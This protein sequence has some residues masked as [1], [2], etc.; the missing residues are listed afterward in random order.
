MYRNKRSLF[1]LVPLL[2]ALSA[3]LAVVFTGAHSGA[4]NAQ[5]QSGV[6]VSNLTETSGVSIG[7]HND[8]AQAFTTGANVTGYT[9]TR[10]DLNV[11]TDSAPNADPL[12]VSIQSE[13]SG[14]PGTILGTLTGPDRL[15]EDPLPFT[16]SG[17]DLDPNTTYFIVMDSAA[18][19][20][21]ELI[22]TESD[23]ESGA[24]GW[25]VANTLLSRTYTSTGAWSTNSETGMVA[26]YGVA[27]VPPSILDL[28]LFY[29]CCIYEER[30]RQQFSMQVAL[31]VPQAERVQVSVSYDLGETADDFESFHVLAFPITAGTKSAGVIVT[32]TPRDDDVEEPE[33]YLTVTASAVIGGATHTDT[34]V[35]KLIDNDAPEPEPVTV[36]SLAVSA[37]GLVT[38]KRERKRGRGQVY[39]LRWVGGGSPPQSADSMAAPGYGNGWTE[40]RDCGDESCRFQIGDFDPELHYLVQVRG[41]LGDRD[42]GWRSAR[43]SPAG[44]GASTG[45]AE[46]AA[47]V[48]PTDLTVGENGGSATYTVSL[49]QPPSGTVNI[50]VTSSDSNAATVNPTSLTFGTGNWSTPQ[51]VTVT[52]VD[53]DVHNP[54]DRRTA[55]ISHSASGGGYDG[56]SVEPVAVTVRDDDSAEETSDGGGDPGITLSTDALY[57]SEDGGG[58]S[59][60]VNLA[61]R[62]EETVTVSV[63]SSDT[64]VATV[65]PAQLQFTPDNWNQRQTV[66]VR[67]VDDDIDNPGDARTARITHTAS[68]RTGSATVTITVRDDETSGNGGGGSSSGPGITLST[69]ALAISEDGGGSYDVNLTSRPEGTVTVSV[70]SLDTGT[71]RVEVSSL[72]FTPDNWNQRQTVSVRAVDDDIDNPG[73]ARVTVI[74]NT[75]SSG[76]DSALVTVIVRD[77]D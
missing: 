55:T 51:R 17:I 41:V 24:A 10:V 29:Q 34:Q 31:A 68:G 26:V 37:E 7:F 76:G 11:G 36:V 54:G 74:T 5:S 35:L 14:R 3:A 38:W 4:V 32:A 33:K 46:P 72:T 52:G 53:D 43:Y 15:Y 44:S 61:S 27:K 1:G 59:Y 18:D 13:S 9:L 47:S 64:S 48:S 71:V 12:S 67:S 56:V 66:S 39:L 40:G 25:S 73:D 6:L 45:D 58:G 63:S 57:P 62:P 69:Y 22:L 23:D 50:S 21:A 65:S 49:E 2:A 28:S 70:S 16:H 42:K 60:Y 30:G 19:L 77:N 8:L 20:D 75:A